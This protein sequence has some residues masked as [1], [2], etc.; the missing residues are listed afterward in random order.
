M[1]GNDIRVTRSNDQSKWLIEVIDRSLRDL[2][3]D[4][5]VN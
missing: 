1:R 3:E 5:E 2:M 4:H